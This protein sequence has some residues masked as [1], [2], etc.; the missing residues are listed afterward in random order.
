MADPNADVVD[1]NDEFIEPD[2]ASGGV[3][4]AAPPVPSQP[5]EEEL[6]EA[7]L[8]V[9]SNPDI[10][11]SCFGEDLATSFATTFSTDVRQRI[12]SAVAF[13]EETDPLFCSVAQERVCD[14]YQQSQSCCCTTETSK[15]RQCLFNKVITEQ[16]NKPDCKDNCNGGGGGKGG[17][18]MITMILIA[19]VAILATGIGYVVYRKRRMRQTK[20]GGNTECDASDGEGNKSGST[21]KDNIE[22][23]S[24]GFDQDAVDLETGGGPEDMLSNSAKKRL[25]SEIYNLQETK[26]QLQNEVN[27]L[28]HQSD[29]PSRGDGSGNTAAALQ[30]AQQELE[31]LRDEQ[32]KMSRKLSKLKLENSEMKVQLGLKKSSSSRSLGRLDNSDDNDS[33]GSKGGG[34]DVERKRRSKKEAEEKLA[35]AAKN[36]NMTLSI[37]NHSNLDSCDDGD[38]DEERRRRR[39]ERREARKSESD[40]NFDAGDEDKRKSHRRRASKSKLMDDEEMSDKELKDDGEDGKEERKRSK[41]CSRS[42]SKH[43]ISR[44]DREVRRKS[45][46]KSLRSMEDEDAEGDD[47]SKE[48]R[49][50]SRKSSKR[51]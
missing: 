22:E 2:P 40:S 29:F 10:C 19:V 39:R 18:S 49:R 44:E 36:A 23:Q 35:L 13:V 3:E 6:Q 21:H 50:K 17:G 15:Y 46:S 32:V 34:D 37:S 31:L 38:D 43:K 20:G 27:V 9:L 30:E 47:D 28:R 41:S 24:F 25:K 48:K 8:C 7:N 33:G 51:R 1:P 45:S 11:A 16:F 26:L 12:F 42:S 14:N 4:G 5:C